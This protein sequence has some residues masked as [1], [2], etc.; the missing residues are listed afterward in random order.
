VLLPKALELNLSIIVISRNSLLMYSR[1]DNA[2]TVDKSTGTISNGGHPIRVHF[3]A[4]SDNETLIAILKQPENLEKMIGK[5]YSSAF[6]QMLIKSFLSSFVQSICGVTRDINDMICAGR[7]LWLNYT[8][9]LGPQQIDDT[10]KLIE[11]NNDVQKALLSHLDERM[12]KLSK[13]IEKS[14]ISLDH[15]PDGSPLH[16]LPYLVKCLLLASFICQHNRADKDKQLFSIVGSGKRRA[17]QR[18]AEDNPESVAYATWD[19][20]RLKALR[21]RS[22]PLERMLSIFVN[23]VGQQQSLTYA[24][25][26]KDFIAS[27]G[28][29]V[30]LETISQLHSM[31]L[32]RETVSD[33][34][35]QLGSPTY[36]CDLSRDDANHLAQSISFPLDRYLVGK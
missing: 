9:P 8:E 7:R 21:P 12:V 6:H 10:L 5:G 1:I 18:D 13:N 27:L 17:K 28:N 26:T 35:V 34:G 11:G 2:A 30:F 31:G 16:D 20:Q 14:I 22:F 33:D 29:T 24:T 4:Y 36:C 3:G 25:S 32:I 15:M 19:Q 23:L